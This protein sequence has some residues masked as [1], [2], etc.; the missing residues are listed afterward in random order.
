M[1]HWELIKAVPMLGSQ[2]KTYNDGH[3]Y[4]APSGAVGNARRQDLAN[5]LYRIGLR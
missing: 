4:Y 1:S 2:M 3:F 5:Y